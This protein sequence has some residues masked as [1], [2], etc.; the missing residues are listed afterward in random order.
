MDAKKQKYINELYHD[1]SENTIDFESF[2]VYDRELLKKH[3][4]QFGKIISARKQCPSNDGQLY[5][6]LAFIPDPPNAIYK[7][8]P[9]I[10]DPVP[11]N[12]KVEVQH[13]KDV[14]M[15]FNL[16]DNCS[17]MYMMKGSGVFYDV[18]QT[19]AFEH[20]EDAVK[21]FLNKTCSRGNGMSSVNCDNEQHDLMEAAK[22]QNYDSIQFLKHTDQRC[23][24]MR[25]EIIDLH[26]FG[27]Q[28]CGTD[29]KYLS[30]GKNGQI[31]CKCD[32]SKSHLNCDLTLTPK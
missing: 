28:A 23:G 10:F 18:G 3:D 16:E 30:T 32:N 29:E 25:A 14:D 9:P 20:H 27:Q 31:P 12:T 11:S 5:T 4:L 26:G 7:W 19:I 6:D 21:Y 24:L 17:W 1:N 15:R 2:D 13:V 8:K 22:S